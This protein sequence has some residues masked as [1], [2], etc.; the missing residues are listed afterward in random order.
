[1]GNTCLEP[2]DDERHVIGGRQEPAGT[3]RLGQRAHALPF[4]RV[5][6][7]ATARVRAHAWARRRWGGGSMVGAARWRGRVGAVVEVQA[8][9]HCD[10]RR[11]EA[12][13]HSD[14][15]RGGR[16]RDQRDRELSRKVEKWER[17][18][19]SELM[20]MQ[21]A[22]TEAR[23]V[24]CTWRAT[25]TQLQGAR[26]R[27]RTSSATGIGASHL[28]GLGGSVATRSCSCR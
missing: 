22:R 26:R 11:R 4:D 5:Q 2:R 18:S 14:R 3:R 12:S 8:R 20:R 1:V 27:A 24:V 9:C 16:E 10:H 21:G 15:A 28:P 19:E 17:E 13:N 6:R 7:R 25:T 23:G